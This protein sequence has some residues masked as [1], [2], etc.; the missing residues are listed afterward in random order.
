MHLHHV[1]RNVSPSPDPVL[2]YRLAPLIVANRTPSP[3][4]SVAETFPSEP[5]SP[6]V[7]SN[8]PLT[9]SSPTPPSTQIL[10]SVSSSTA[11]PT[12]PPSHLRPPK[13][14]ANVSSQ[15]SAAFSTRTVVRK[16]PKLGRARR[17]RSIP[18]LPLPHLS[19]HIPFPTG[20]PPSQS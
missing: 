12:Q 3:S 7:P 16:L 15:D 20:T 8:P 13:P 2:Q 9:G 5:P 18:T 11:P 4:P 14:D 17:P 19:T 6:L 1:D 10:P